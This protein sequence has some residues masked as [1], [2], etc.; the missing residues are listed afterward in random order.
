MVYT[1]SEGDNWSAELLAVVDS[2]GC[3]SGDK[4]YF[5]LPDGRIVRARVERIFRDRT[6]YDTFRTQRT[7]EGR[8]DTWL[9]H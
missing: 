7:D 6:E 1:F 3:D 4:L 9:R 5:I 8:V 2:D